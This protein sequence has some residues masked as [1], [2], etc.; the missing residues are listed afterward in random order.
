M[1]VPGTA[2]RGGEGNEVFV[3]S[4]HNWSSVQ[5]EPV[6]EGVGMGDKGDCDSSSSSSSS[7]DE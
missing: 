3:L 1:Y 4:A 7:A 5:G 2:S 6:S